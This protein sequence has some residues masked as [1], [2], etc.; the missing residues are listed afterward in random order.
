MKLVKVLFFGRL[1]EILNKDSLSIE[2]SDD[3]DSV[4]KLRTYLACTYGQVWE[5]ELNQAN[6]V[7]SLNQTVVPAETAIGDGDEV[8]FFPP[9]TGG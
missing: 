5:K 3:L 6:L 8:A 2:L 4:G 9:M 1:R 7:M